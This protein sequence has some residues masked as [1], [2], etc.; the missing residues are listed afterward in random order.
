MSITTD[1]A[2]NNLTFLG[3]VETA[4]SAGNLEFNVKNHHV[5]CLDHVINLAAQQIL[6]SLNVES[7]IE[8]DIESDSNNMQITGGTTGYLYKVSL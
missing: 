5:R 4:F 1:N 2:S 3:A 7:N 6:Q 8:A